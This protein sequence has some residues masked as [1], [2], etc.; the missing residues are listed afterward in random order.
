M[1]VAALGIGLNSGMRDAHLYRTIEIEK[2]RSVS[3]KL[4]REIVYEKRWP[5]TR[6]RADLLI[7]NFISSF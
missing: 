7:G 2:E 6:A 1:L 3:P 4:T 5:N